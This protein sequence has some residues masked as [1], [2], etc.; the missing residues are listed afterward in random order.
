MHRIRLRLP[1]EREILPAIE[2]ESRIRFRRRFGSPRTLDMGERV[3]LSLD[4]ITGSVEVLL[5]EV[6]LGTVTVGTTCAR[7]P[8]AIALELRNVIE[9]IQ[10]GGDPDAMMPGEIALEFEMTDA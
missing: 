10:T 8:I 9:I 1:W 3:F 6:R 4:Q 7:L 5:N 2:G